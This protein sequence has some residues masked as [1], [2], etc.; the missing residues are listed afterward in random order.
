MK[1]Q[2]YIAAAA[3]DK[4]AAYSYVLANYA[5]IVARGT[6]LT[7]GERKFDDS[8]CGHV[9]I[10]RAMRSATN[11]AEGVADI[12]VVLDE[13]I[14][15]D[16]GFELLGVNPPLYPTLCRTTQRVMKRFNSC[17]LA[18]MKKGDD[19]SPEEASVFDM[20]LEALDDAMTPRGQFRLAWDTVT[21]S[22]KIIR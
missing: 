14:A 6:F 10:Q 13:N 15:N 2:L 3:D 22:N 11:K 18:A 9:A 21:G 7:V 16:V 4:R 12:T 1:Y 19:L 20:C 8:F 17:E 5:G